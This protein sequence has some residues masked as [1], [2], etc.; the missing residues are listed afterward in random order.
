VETRGAV[1]NGWVPVRC[2]SQNGW[3]SAAYMTL[4][5]NPSNPAPT[6]TPTPAPPSGSTS[7]AMVSGTGGGGLNCRVA[8]VSGS[9]I[10]ILPEGTRV[11]V[12]GS[13]QNGWAQVRCAGQIGWAAASYLIFNVGS[14]SGSGAVWIDVNLTKQYVTVYQGSR[15]IGQTYAS[16]GRYG[17][18]TPPGT[19]YVNYKLTSQTMSG[20]LGGEYYYVQDVP[21]VMYFTDRG[22]AIHGAYWHNNF[23][24]R[25][26]HGCV[27]L[28]V[29]FAQWLY[30]ISPIGTRVYIHY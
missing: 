1:S 17:F 12:F 25:M 9:V 21:W 13:P 30:G 26:S 29:G 11:E 24:Y 5:S 19:Y 28:P 8:K 3:V 22:H 2:A 15:I 7:Y 10:T 18:D 27:N 20:V 16:T 6:P 4:S 14:G 23:G